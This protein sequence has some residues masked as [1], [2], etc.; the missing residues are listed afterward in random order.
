VQHS[1]AL[2]VAAKAGLP[3]LR[4]DIY[5][6]S[7]Q[8][9]KAYDTIARIGRLQPAGANG[10]L[11]K[12][13]NAEVLDP[14]QSWPLTISYYDLGQEGKDATPVYELSFLYFANGVSRNL[15]LD[16]GDFALKGEL[17]RFE[18]LPA[19]ECKPKP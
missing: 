8:G 14:L 16:Y 1:I 11:P 19:T 5:D 7:E 3:T 18:L 15:K 10:R 12:V 4:A 13:E 2:L 6:G 17:S 9:T